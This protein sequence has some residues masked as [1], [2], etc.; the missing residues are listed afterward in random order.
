MNR[1]WRH[2]TARGGLLA[3]LWLCTLVAGCGSESQGPE[4]YPV[5]GRVTYKGE[6]MAGVTLTFHA[7][8]DGIDAQALTD[9]QGEFDVYTY[10]NNGQS[11]KR[12]MVADEYRVSAVK[13]DRESIKS[14]MQPPKNLLPAPYAS[15][16][17][18]Q[19]TLTVAAGQET[20]RTFELK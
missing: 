1:N 13:L 20:E 2:L 17:S 5:T 15:P 19:L 14:T 3:S 4:T 9:D 16:D 8:G 10:F 11:E 6:P 12:G 18:S 7:K